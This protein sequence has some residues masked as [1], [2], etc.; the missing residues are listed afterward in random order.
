MISTIRT[1]LEVNKYLEKHNLID[2]FKKAVQKLKIGQNAGLD[3]K[4]REPKSLEIWS[5]R[6]TK[7]YR[8]WCKKEQNI[9]NVYCID[10]HQ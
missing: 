4:K 2:N 6:L 10:D 5:F 1:S 9:L 8:A 7:K 3:F